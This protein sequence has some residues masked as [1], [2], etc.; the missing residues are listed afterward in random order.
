MRVQTINGEGKTDGVYTYCCCLDPAYFVEFEDG[1]S[2]YF[3]VRECK[4]LDEVDD[5][6]D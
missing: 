6:K 2:G 5:G 3:P 1:Y 4:T